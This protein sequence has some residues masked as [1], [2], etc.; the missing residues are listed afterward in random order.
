MLDWIFGGGASS[1]RDTSR[2]R[3]LEN[4][5]KRIESKLDVVLDELG[6][7]HKIESIDVVLVSDGGN[8]LAMVK[9]VKENFSYS[10]VEAQNLV[11][12]MP[13]TLA[14]GLNDEEAHVFK[15]EFER[16]GGSIELVSSK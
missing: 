7:E 16:M 8:K 5:L 9:A 15:S 3:Q 2:Y 1:E 11:K 14:H 4:R 12:N 10:L 13:S 6:L